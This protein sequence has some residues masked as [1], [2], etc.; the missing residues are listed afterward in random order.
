MGQE[1]VRAP[2][3]ALIVEPNRQL[4]LAIRAL[5]LKLGTLDATIAAW[6]GKLTA[7]VDAAV[8]RWFDDARA[9]VVLA[10]R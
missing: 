2:R 9:S 6:K 3:C 5:L 1:Q 7:S 4:S 10:G 8:D